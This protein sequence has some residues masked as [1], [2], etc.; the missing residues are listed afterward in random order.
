MPGYAN[1]IYNDF[2]GLAAL[3]HQAHEDQTGSLERVSKQFESLFVQMMVK[4]MRQASF[5]GGVFDSERTRFY[6]DMYD[7]QLSLHLSES[8]GIGL[9]AMLRRQLG[10]GSAE[11]SATRGLGG[12]ESYRR[13]PAPAPR[14]D[15]SQIMEGR[16]ASVMSSPEQ[17]VQSLWPA[18]ERAASSLGLP[19]EALLAQAA[20]E[21]GWGSQ[22]MPA[23]GGRNSHNLF[24][25]KADRRW[26]GAQVRRETLE[27]E[28][29]VPVRRR[30]NFRAYGSYDE[31]FQDYVNFLKGS[32]R[33]AEALAKTHDSQAYFKALQQ[34]G[35]ATDPQYAQKILRLMQGPEMQLALDKVKGHDDR[36]I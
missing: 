15:S 19:P 29:G 3:K 34:A 31:S 23:P 18:A 9:G 22:V 5:G 27:F 24:G 10:G 2:Q 20:L 14:V 8:G 13:R 4:Q 28:A 36:P 21:T 35:Y 32:P 26:Q 17:F 16:T 11:A 6:Q 1:S 33:Y 30:E 7:R 12:L 25:I